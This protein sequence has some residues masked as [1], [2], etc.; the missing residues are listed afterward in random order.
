[1]KVMKMLMMTMRRDKLSMGACGDGP[2]QH[3]NRKQFPLL[4]FGVLKPSTVS[5][6]PDL[7]FQSMF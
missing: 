7:L 3:L 4:S 1:M 5:S 2:S 6:T